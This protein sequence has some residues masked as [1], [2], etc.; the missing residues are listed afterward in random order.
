MSWVEVRATFETDLF[1]LS[2]MIELYRDFGIDNTLEEPASL[3][4]CLIDVDGTAAR[5]DGLK[6]ALLG[7]GALEVHTRELPEDNW[8]QAWKA[9]FKPRRVG[10][11]IVVRPTWEEFESQPGDVVIVLDP[12]QAFG[13]GDHPHPPACVWNS[14]RTA[15]PEENGF[16][17]SAA[18]AEFSPWARASSVQARWRQ[19]TSI[20]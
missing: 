6:A 14:S 8:E 3:T 19:P 4:G 11:H 18:A 5:I 1:D 17:I 10:R 9:F 13:T 7:A 15:T 16:W 12:G 20:P 2:P